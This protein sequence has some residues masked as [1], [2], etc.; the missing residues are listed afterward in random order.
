MKGWVK[1]LSNIDKHILE[2][3]ADLHG[4]PKGAYNIRKNG[5]GVDRS[6]T[7]NIEI[8]TKIDKPGID[9]IVKPGTKGETVHI[10]VILTVE[11]LHDVV[12][13][14]F[15]I[16]EGADVTVIAGCGIHNPGEQ[17]ARHD[18]VHDFIVRKGAR[19]RY[20][21][22][23]YGEGKGSGKKILNPRTIVVIEE[24]GY[25]EME[26]IQISGVDNTM[27]ETEARLHDNAH[28]F[29]TERMLTDGDQF[30]ESRIT[31]ELAGLDSSTQV[32]SRSVAKDSSQQIFYPRAVGLNRCRA[33][34]QCDAI[35]MDSAKI[36]SIPEISAQ[37]ADSQL[38]HEAAI[39]KIA[40][41]Q[42]IKLMTLGLSE[43]DAEDT[44]LE[45]FLK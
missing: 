31:V 45:G 18:G 41:E 14:T 19:M 37:H 12:Y 40:G 13:N 24:D 33:H 42:L 10:P 38:V 27:R 22:K 9:I 36:R 39:G 1:M 4:T 25:A 34:V 7:P 2:I 29:V 28:L 35:I 23:H 30:A 44:I 5:A 15:D 32:I 17:N 20:V 43:K 21:E 3:V 26:L 8:R 6:I 16:G 11:G